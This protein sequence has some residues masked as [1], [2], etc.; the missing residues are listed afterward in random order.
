M[1]RPIQIPRPAFDEDTTYYKQLIFEGELRY[2]QAPL[3]QKR[4]HM[5]VEHGWDSEDQSCRKDR[6][7]VDIP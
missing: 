5:F 6:V 2:A 1:F 7:R 3:D 4:L